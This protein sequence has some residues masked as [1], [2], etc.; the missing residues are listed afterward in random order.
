MA[1]RKRPYIPKVKGCYEC[2]QRRINCDGTRPSCSK[3]VSRGIACSGFDIKYRFRDGLPQAQRTVKRR[4]RNLS[5]LHSGSHPEI[6]AELSQDISR[7]DFNDCEK[8]TQDLL[9]F[10]A[11]P[12]ESNDEAFDWTSP[13]NSPLVPHS[14]NPSGSVNTDFLHGLEVIQGLSQVMAPLVPNF[15]LGQSE[16][17][18]EFLL[19]YF[20]NNIAP[21]MVVVDDANNGW[22]HLILPMAHTSEV[23]MSAVLAASAFHLS[24]RDASQTIAD[25]HKLYG[26]AI[27]ELQRRRDLTGCDRKAK[28]VVI[29]AIVVLLV[30]VMI[31]GCSDFPII[32]QMLESALDAVGGEGGLLDGSE[33]AKFSLRQIRKLRVYAAPLLSQDAGLHAMIYRAEESFDCLHYY[34]RLHPKQ[35]HMFKAIANIRQQAFNIYL[36]RVL[37]KDVGSVPAGAIDRFI[38]SVQAFPEGTPGE[39]VLIWPVFIAA[40]ESSTLEHQQV[41]EE[42]LERQYHRNG[43]FNILRGLELLRKIWARSN[44]EDWPALLPEPQVFIM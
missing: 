22:R 42:F 21:E 33:M 7:F 9:A 31:N 32:F 12:T 4:T 18:M 6:T 28:Q 24:G 19:T 43:F 27:Q 5:L 10:E 41:F 8:N 3:C 16:L 30:A 23:M 38:T 26:Q 20:S 44:S 37:S 34:D 13:T 15:C 35:S 2:S 17:R 1:R 25:P 11:D 29:L 36:D 40:S 39:H 14:P